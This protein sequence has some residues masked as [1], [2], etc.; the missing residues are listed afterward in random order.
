MTNTFY[1][2]TP[3][4][5]ANSAPH[6]GSLYTT[7]VADTLARVHRQRGDETFFLTGTDEH[8]IN[9]QRVASERALTPKQHV[10]EIVSEFER[11][12]A[13]YHL[14]TAHGGYDIFMRTTNAFHYEGV[15]HLWRTVRES[16]TPKGNE[17]IYKGFY[18]GWFCPNCA[19]F[20]T[21]DEYQKP[22]REGESPRCLVHLKPL[23]RVAEESYFFRLSDYGEYL[24]ELYARQPDLIQPEARRNE[25]V[26]FIK[27][28]LQDLSVSRRSESISWA[29]PVPDD[30]SHTIYVWFDALSNY[31]TAIGYGNREREQAVGFEKFWYGA[32]HLVGNDILRFHTVY[33]HSFLTAA[34]LPLPKIVFAHGMWLDGEGRKWSKTLGNAI[35]PD[36]LKPFFTPDM[37]RYFVLRQMVFGQ[38]GR[39]SFEN[40][41]DRTNSDLASGLGNLAARTLSMINRYFAG[42]IPHGDLKESEYLNARRAGVQPDAQEFATSLSLARNQYVARFEAFDFSRALEAAWTIVARADKF[43]SDAKPWDLAKDATMRN[44]LAVVLYRASESLRWLAVLLAPVMPDAMN[45]LWRH[46]GLEKEIA[47]PNLVDPRSLVW[48]ELKPGTKIG[49]TQPL[50]PRLDKT[51]ILDEI[52]AKRFTK[53]MPQTATDST[54]LNDANPG[55]DVDS[56]AAAAATQSRETP[57]GIAS[58]ITIDDFVKVEMRVG[59]I[60]TAER[61]PKSDKLL[62]FEIDLGEARPRQILAGIA[63]HYEP[64]TLVG[65]KIAVVS[66]LAP[67]KLR[68]YESQGMVLAASVEGGKP[69]LATFGEDVPNG[70]RLK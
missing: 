45:E 62:R 7:I 27:G 42:A 4:Y 41:I 6:T 20:K 68:G 29:I 52:E 46:L 14:D 49:V 35:Y 67:R 5:Y 13:E 61:V 30:D 10:D 64:E 25:V 58:F 17:P 28:G 15:S 44:T 59:E 23:D 21:E 33:W 19:A 55:N 70:A 37:I 9:I 1:V 26:S 66:N 16:K 57:E 24:L 32:V 8:G 51:K 11:V 39:M 31:I 50:F 34:N 48:S 38:D 3:I 43:L 53:N 60:K 69:V 40:I 56:T 63:E 12:F 22:E 18:E 65:R 2:T 36:D 47:S 54:P